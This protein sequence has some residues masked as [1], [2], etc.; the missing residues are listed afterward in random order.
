[1]Q[2]AAGMESKLEVE[3]YAIAVGVEGDSGV[4]T[5]NHQLEIVGEADII[6]LPIRAYILY[7]NYM[8]NVNF[9]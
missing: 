2:V 3:I 6:H 9:Q 1:M 5:I 7:F 4:G 8:K